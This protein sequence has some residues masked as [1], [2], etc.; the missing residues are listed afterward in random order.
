MI[1]RNLAAAISTISGRVSLGLT[2]TLA[3][4]LAL[5]LTLALNLTLTLTLTRR[6][7]LGRRGKAAL[8]AL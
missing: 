4:A 1:S 3:L 7:K 2:L 8:L 6:I 5:T